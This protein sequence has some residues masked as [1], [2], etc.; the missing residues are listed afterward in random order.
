[1]A[2]HNMTKERLTT[3]QAEHAWVGDHADGG[4]LYLQ[5]R[6]TKA[7]GLSRSW[8][9]R[10]TLN[11]RAR[12]MGLGAFDDWS[13]AEARGKA[14]EARR[15]RSEGIDPI[16]ARDAQRA[17]QRVSAATTITFQKAA[18]A[19]IDA[20]SAG[21]RGGD[22]QHQWRQSLRDYA[23]P[24][25]GG[26]PVAAIDTGLVMRAI[27]PIW[28]TKTVTASRVRGR[29]ESILGWAATRGY[30]QGENPA[31]WK[32][33]LENL[34]PAKGKVA[35]VEH[36][37]ALPYPEIGAFM[38][39]LRQQEGI[40]GRALQF[41]ILT[42]ARAGEVMGA[43]WSE[44]NLADR[45]W[46][47][48][49][50]RMKNGKEH[51]VPL[52]DAA[53]AILGPQGEPKSFVFAGARGQPLHVTAFLMVLRRLDCAVT[54]HGFRSTFMDWATERTNFPAEMRDLALAHTV[55]DKVE[56]AYRRGDMF[57][58]RRK[59]MD[60]WAGFCTGEASGKVVRLR[61]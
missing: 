37:A 31:R 5:V 38:T 59:L 40:A 16:D 33:H 6:R 12:E 13:L 43:R 8:L 20:H 27:E 26:L 7:G 30:R 2:A 39:K 45:L 51:R 24:V 53:M 1:M 49:G 21:W 60:A 50:E 25:L 35:P 23:F 18:E 19:Y 36:H 48:P 47:V 10:F 28:K 44:I 29:I 57:E 9:F 42:A 46:T 22:S 4:G 17:A 34:L 3:K 55:S 11:G 15:L 14:R 58:R 54:A 41:T 56:A 32:G 52:S 61:G